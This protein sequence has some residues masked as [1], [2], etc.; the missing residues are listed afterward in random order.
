MIFD[1][2]K[3]YGFSKKEATNLSGYLK[4]I[5]FRDVLAHYMANYYNDVEKRKI[6]QYSTF[7]IDLCKKYLKDLQLL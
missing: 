4:I 1:F 7:L 3:H 6:T 5:D 2:F